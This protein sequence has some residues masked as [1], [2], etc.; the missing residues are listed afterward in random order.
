MNTNDKGIS[1][2]YSSLSK[3]EQ[4]DRWG[5]AAEQMLAA[6]QDKMQFYAAYQ[7]AKE[8]VRTRN[9]AGEGR[10]KKRRAITHAPSSKQAKKA[11]KAT[12]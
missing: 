4:L 2:L 3:A 11:K 9:K 1:K 7:G 10:D 5:E 8:E 12:Q 6:A